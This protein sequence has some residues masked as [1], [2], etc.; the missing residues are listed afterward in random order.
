MLG[1]HTLHI[2]TEH[3]HEHERRLDVKTELFLSE[4][5]AEFQG[6]GITHP[7]PPP[8]PPLHPKEKKLLST[9]APAMYMYL[10][11]YYVGKMTTRCSIMISHLFKTIIVSSK[12]ICDG[13]CWELL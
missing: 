1:K 11:T 4:K 9:L 8:P 6:L 7:P 2:R 3:G 12:D 13:K 5:R 10:L